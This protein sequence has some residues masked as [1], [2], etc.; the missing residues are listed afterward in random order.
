MARQFVNAALGEGVLAV[1]GIE[2][3]GNKAGAGEQDGQRWVRLD[4]VCA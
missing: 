4:D 3:L 2:K 1:G